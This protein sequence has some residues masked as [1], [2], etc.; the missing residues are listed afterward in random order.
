MNQ[1]EIAQRQLRDYDQHRPGSCF[2]DPGFCLSLDE[3]Y[4]LQFEVARMRM[5]RGEKILGYKIGCISKTIQ[6]QLGINHPI[7]GH[8]W[9]SESYTSGVT[10]HAKNFENL[11][12]EGEFAIRLA[13]NVPSADWLRKNPDVIET[14]FVV[15]ELHNYILRGKQEIRACELIANNAIH[16]GVVMPIQETRMD[17]AQEPITATIR[18]S[19]NNRLLG[20]TSMRNSAT[21]P[22]EGLIR[23]AEHLENF[24]RCL[25]RGQMILTG[26][27]L[28][29]WPVKDGDLIQVTSNQ[30]GITSVM[31][32]ATPLTK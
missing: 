11:A 22:L 13:D 26:S 8:I 18:V 27:P 9:N 4:R 1:C 29:L 17:R 25:L 23:L 21:T 31:Q 30:F 3:A 28:P 20:E 2:D 16:A 10:L 15:I 12:I 5:D 19:K 7:F 6:K 14:S 32:V 24:D